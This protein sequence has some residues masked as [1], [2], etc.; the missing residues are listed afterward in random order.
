MVLH[1]PN[2]HLLCVLAPARRRQICVLFGEMLF[3]EKCPHRQRGVYWSHKFLCQ[4]M[5]KL[6]DNYSLGSAL[7]RLYCHRKQPVI[8]TDNR[9]KKMANTWIHFTS[10]T[11]S[12]RRLR[13]LDACCKQKRYDLRERETAFHAYQ[14]GERG[15]LH[16]G[17]KLLQGHGLIPILLWHQSWA[18]QPTLK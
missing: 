4:P 10:I 12:L 9:K 6:K 11:M 8:A 2:V 1:Q 13:L 5:T 18:Y 3:G 14:L 7:G 15:T 16:Q 17:I